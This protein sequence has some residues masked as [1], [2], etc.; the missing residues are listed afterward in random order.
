LNIN[1]TV[2][3]HFIFEIFLKINYTNRG[4]LSII[5]IDQKFCDNILGFNTSFRVDI[6]AKYEKNLIIIELKYRSDRTQQADNALKCIK[7]K[8][9]SRE[10]YKDIEEVNEVVIALSTAGKLY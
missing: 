4:K 1:E 10:S 7:F 9:T 3:S 2:I 6:L 8:N 5:G